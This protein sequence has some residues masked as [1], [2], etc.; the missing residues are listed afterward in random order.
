M[1]YISY[2]LV[3][4]YM[5]LPAHVQ[6]RCWGVDSLKEVAV[7]RFQTL[8]LLLV[9]AMA[10]IALFLGRPATAA[11]FQ[12]IVFSPTVQPDDEFSSSISVSDDGRYVTFDSLA[13]NLVVEESGDAPGTHDVFRLDRLT[14]EIEWVTG[15]GG[16]TGGF[17]PRMSGDGQHV[18]FVEE[19]FFPTFFAAYVMNLTTFEK[20]RVDV[21]TGGDGGNG[22]ATVSA[23]SDNG[24]LILFSSVAT[25]LIADLDVDLFLRDTGAGTT[26]RIADAYDGDINDDGQFVAYVTNS[27]AVFVL[28]RNTSNTEQIDVST[29]GIP[30]NAAASFV[31]ISGDGRFVVFES[32]ASNLVAGDTNGVSDVFLRDRVLGTTERVSEGAGGS[33]AN[34][35]SHS[36]GNAVSDNGRYV[37]FFSE[38][39]SGLTV[40]P[41]TN[42]VGDW[43]LRDR[44]LDSTE[45]VH[46]GWQGDQANGAGAIGALS[47]S[48][49]DIAIAS[50]ATNLISN[51]TNG[52]TDAFVSS[53]CPGATCGNG[54][55]D[56][57]RCEQCD[58]GNTTSG[59][60]CSDQC[61]N[62]FCGDAIV[63]AGT[64]EECDDGNVESE[65]GC[66][67]TC[68]NEFCGDGIVQI[69][70]GE[71]CEPTLEPDDCEV[72]CT[73]R[74]TGCPYN[75]CDCLDSAGGFPLLATKLNA[76]PGKYREE[77]IKYVAEVRV[78]GDACVLTTKLQGIE[79]GVTEI[80]GDLI[81][82]ADA[83]TRNAAKFKGY[84]VNKILQPGIDIPGDLITA[85]AELPVLDAV[86]L[87]GVVDTSGA[88]PDLSPCQS[89][90]QDLAE[91]S[92]LLAGLTPVDTTFE[93]FKL[94]S[95]FEL[96]A[97][98]GISVFNFESINLGSYVDD[99]VK[100]GATLTVKQHP[101]TVMVIL[102]VA[103][104]VKLGNETAIFTDGPK[105]QVVLNI[106]GEK[107]SLSLGKFAILEIPAL[108]PNGK[109]KAGVESFISNTLSGV[110]GSKR[111]GKM[112][113]KGATFTD[114]LSC[115]P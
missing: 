85:G 57:Y 9:G 100:I 112:S 5:N 3:T 59:D 35:P 68:L 16:G 43:F 37:L 61:Q 22:P 105:E 44:T 77:G 99:G 80:Q 64:G 33:Q 26:T 4:F 34:G 23:L 17:F 113:V 76:K 29:G 63:Q 15:I 94:K 84:K 24:Q 12:R 13:T 91:A 115:T 54:A 81:L 69:G 11:V 8:V 48:G 60:G 25:N 47:A 70:L 32:E 71:E 102:N 6:R 93:K 111:G 92:T 114:R 62:E 88:H 56:D 109:V 53:D 40:A 42:G 30:G 103:G 72:P 75:L 79:N 86:Q 7:L 110:P 1:W 66:S 41:D 20:Q 97:G 18:A 45:N 101:N 98:P 39:T 90:P 95:E 107:G 108:I 49:E 58:D 19:A 83:E 36:F 51:D 50:A 104:K 74:R 96:T 31:T 21:T 27:E 55:I 65:D 28:D 106:H 78:A 10:F 2:I 87:G 52:F 82:R 38:A 89:A 14:N 67:S 46:L 73:Y